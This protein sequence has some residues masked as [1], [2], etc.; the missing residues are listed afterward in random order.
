MKQQTGKTDTACALYESR[1]CAIL[2]QRSC[3]DC[4]VH[5]SE[6]G[7]AEETAEFVERFE[8]LLPEDGIAYLFES[9]TCVL[10]KTEPKGARSGYAILDFGHKEPKE[11]AQRKLMQKQSV[12]FMV[13]LQFACCRK[14]R[15]R[16]LLC[17]YLPLL[18][19]IV[20][21]ALISPVLAN[22]HWLQSLRAVAGWLPFVLVAVL[23]GVG[24][25]AGRILQNVLGKRF[26]QKMYFDLM[27][28]P[29]SKAMKKRGW[30]PLFGEKRIVPVFT[31]KR[32]RYGL[33]AASTKSLS[34]APRDRA[35]EEAKN[36]DFIEDFSENEAISD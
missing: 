36:P 22:P 34:N 20:P 30:F 6:G 14:C 35:D 15:A 29:A 26:E 13:P 12:G 16:L 27:G 1:A 11:L 3:A 2:N 5:Q 8:Q 17:E 9:K 23:A 32:I 25:A 7:C 33:G 21:L 28:H 24:Y 18:G 4:P 31:K 19:P 10:C